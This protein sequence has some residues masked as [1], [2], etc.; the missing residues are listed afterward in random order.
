MEQFRQTY[1]QSEYGQYGRYPIYNPEYMWGGTVYQK[2]SWIVHMILYVLGEETCWDF[3]AEWRNRYE[4]DVGNT[5]QLQ[6]TLEDVAG[7]DLD[8]FY[9]EWVYM[10]GFP[11]Y[12]WGWIFETLGPDSNTVSVSIIQTQPDT[13][14]TPLVF[15]MPVEFG[16]TTTE[17]YEMHTVW[18]DQRNP[19]FSFNVYGVPLSVEFDPD[20]WILKTQ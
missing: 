7:E 9:D 16:V 4:Y 19:N 8:W 2:G 15:T 10:A 12:E 1:F 13:A 17:G 5:A 18:N 20:I 14:Q 6:E 11:E 3:F